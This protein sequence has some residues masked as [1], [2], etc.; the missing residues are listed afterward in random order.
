MY[1]V[2]LLIVYIIPSAT[3][4]IGVFTSRKNSYAGA[5]AIAHLVL[6]TVTR[7]EEHNRILNI[8]PEHVTFVP[9]F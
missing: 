6:V 3:V 9:L 4:D 5:D 7:V 1:K 2:L 8:P